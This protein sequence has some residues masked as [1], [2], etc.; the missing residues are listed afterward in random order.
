VAVTN[1]VLSHAFGGSRIG[2]GL[3]RVFIETPLSVLFR[4]FDAKQ[5]NDL[6]VGFAALAVK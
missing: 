3:A 5:S 2:R 4:A 1:D 6:A